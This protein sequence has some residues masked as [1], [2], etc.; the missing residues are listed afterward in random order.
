MKKRT[1][2]LI[3]SLLILAFLVSCFS[4]FAFASTPKDNVKS[5]TEG[6]IDLIVN[7]TYDEGWG[8]QNGF[9]IKNAGTNNYT[10][11]YEETEDFGY[12]YFCRL[13]SVDGT[14]GYFRLNYGSSAASYGN[15]IFELDLK[16]DDICNFSNDKKL[17]TIYLTGE[18]NNKDYIL[19]AIAANKLYVPGKGTAVIEKGDRNN[20]TAASY[21]AADLTSEWVHLAFVITLNQRRCTE[22]GKIHTVTETAN[23][24]EP[25]CCLKIEKKPD[26]NGKMVDTVV[27]VSLQDMIKNQL[28]SV[29]IYYGYS[30]TFDAANAKASPKKSA[31]ISLENTYY[32]DITIENGNSNF[33]YMYVGIPLNPDARTQSYM[34]DNVRAYN[35]TD[36]PGVKVTGYGEK[37]DVTATKTETI[38]SEN[39]G[40]TVMEYINSGI[41]M[42][43]GSDYSLTRG[44]KEPVFSDG[45]KAY[46][47]PVKIKGEVYIPLQKVLDWVGFPI[48]PHDDGVSFDISTE[49]GSTFIT[50]GRDTA[51]ANGQT[52]NLKSAPC[53]LKDAETE[54]E[55]VGVSKDD[56]A[57]LVPGYHLTYDE[58]GLIVISEGENLLDRS[59]DLKVMLNVMKEFLFT[60]KSGD[61]FYESAKEQTGNFAHP[62]LFANQEEFNAL[63]VAYELKEG[64][65]GYDAK[66]KGYLTSLVADAEEVYAK[67]ANTD[68]VIDETK[69]YLKEEIV[70]PHSS[71]LVSSKISNNGYSPTGTNDELVA[72]AEEIRL[73]ALACQVTGDLKY[74]YMAY[75]M[76]VDLGEWKHWA[77]AFF[78]NCA[79]ATAA[80]ATA[81]DWLYNIWKD[82][83]KLSLTPIETA[84]YQKGIYVG[85][86]FTVGDTINEEISSNQGVFSVYPERTDSHNVIGTSGMVIASLAMIGSD[87]VK[88]DE[89]QPEKDAMT[90][91]KNILG[92]NIITLVNK[93]LD[94]YAPDGSYIQSPEYWSDAT[95][96]LVRMI[97]AL[98]N[99]IG[100]SLGLTELWGLDTTFYYAY[101]I[102]YKVAPNEKNPEGYDHWNYHES[103]LGV[104]NTDTFLY[105]AK[106]LGDDVIGAIRLEQLETKKASVWDVLAYDAK[107]AD[108]EIA[109]DNISR[110]YFM[111][112]CE[113]FVSRSDFSDTATY[114][115]MMGGPNDST[116]GQIDSGNFI[117]ASGG[118]TWFG[119]LGSDTNQLYEYFN[120]SQRYKYYR[121]TG[122]GNNVVILTT[123]SLAS[124]FPYGQALNGGGVFTKY[125]TNDYGMYAV[126]D[127]SSVYTGKVTYA[128]RGL[129]FTNNRSTVVIQDD[130]RFS[131]VQAC[132]WILHTT[133]ENIVILEDGRT[134]LLTQR[135]NGKD[136]YL[137][138]TILEPGDAS[139]LTFKRIS[140]TQSILSTTNKGNYST[141]LGYAPENDRSAF[142]RLVIEQKEQ[143]SFQC[144]VVIERIEKLN[145][146]K[147]VEYEY[148]DLRTW[149]DSMVKE[150]FTA[151]EQSDDILTTP[152]FTDFDGNLYEIRGYYDNGNAFNKRF[153]DFFRSMVRN[154]SIIK[155]YDP[156]GELDSYLDYIYIDPN[157]TDDPDEPKPEN[158]FET[159]ADKLSPREEYEKYLG[160]FNEFKTEIDS[161]VSDLQPLGTYITGFN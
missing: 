120:D 20:A 136:V 114:V 134:A 55:F 11:E 157:E 21:E 26:E 125:Y 51:T 143:T 58:M 112:S 4:V 67:Y 145:S 44:K 147:P 123:A 17:P 38:I 81:Y 105:A 15:T 7:R 9:D 78:S 48:Y 66:L 91:I 2:R 130:I 73:L 45:D 108:P 151:T 36:V 102:E 70:N 5:V 6:D 77:P 93:G 80:Y 148:T 43:V 49:S 156:T 37:V 60:E 92:S 101:Q 83:C 35:G 30:D 158:P 135:V 99:S 127:N 64:A 153:K 109:F 76:A 39:S 95:G 90:H 113:G 18:T 68:A 82:D 85:N 59:T 74:A 97:W 141:N 72:Y 19:G 79:D 62:Y 129:L 12:N 31:D 65:D 13:E 161:Y 138:M 71:E 10:I 14:E 140:T 28:F 27:G 88:S 33:K 69:V 106:M 124:T 96:A 116:T 149:N 29:R 128:S 34:I 23:H 40:K 144:A 1:Y 87:F 132:T 63:K 154:A 142:S 137:R 46:G 24:Q 118:Y 133:A 53:I 8:Y 52:V 160:K 117:Y 152:V 150:S 155:T 122:E 3:S 84:I 115:G 131:V 47:A 146:S 56:V 104:L 119:D 159:N 110:D 42:K 100:E 25:V 22:C 16:T 57:I 50:V 139:A 126:L 111:E 32:H 86:I 98:E 89:G 61:E 94:A 103:S 75:E 121:V 54:K 107:Y 41:V